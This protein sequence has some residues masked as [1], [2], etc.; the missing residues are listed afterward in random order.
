MLSKLR[1]V[2][3]CASKMGDRRRSTCP[4]CGSAGS[5]LVA[6]KYLVTALRR[7]GECKLMFRT[8]TTTAEENRV[9]Y[10]DLYSQ[11]SVTDM[12]D[13]ERLKSLVDSGFA[14]S[15]RDF[16]PYVKVL[17]ALGMEPGARIL[18]FGCSWGYGSWQLQ[19]SGF[20]VD[21]FEISESRCRFAREKLGVNAY[22]RIGSIPEGKYDV[23]FSAHVLEHVPSVSSAIDLARAKVV[24]GG[25]FVAFTPNGSEGNRR[26]DPA[27]WARLW[28]L[29]HPNFLDD[30]FYRHVFSDV[31]LASGPYDYE[32][33]A[34]AWHR[35][36]VRSLP[37]DG[38]ELL[39]VTRMEG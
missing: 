4:S 14:G 24:R 10:Q 37:L 30:V 25:L 28:G 16:S 36:G 8:P 13:D 27:G 29:N 6:R 17:R 39:A 32:L 21:A 5:T 12:P 9:F 38:Y 34:D 11:G 7:C 35:S 26:R 33:L 23:F 2:F 31:L 18:D 3:T 19:R 1:Y 15:D 22:D 20:E